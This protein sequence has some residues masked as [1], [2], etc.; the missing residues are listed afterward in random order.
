[1]IEAGIH[2]ADTEDL[3]SSILY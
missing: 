2:H 3:I 1:L